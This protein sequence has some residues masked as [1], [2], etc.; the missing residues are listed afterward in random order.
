[1]KGF[2]ESLMIIFLCSRQQSSGS[3]Q[4]ETEKGKERGTKSIYI[5]YFIHFISN[6]PSTENI[7]NNH[8][9]NRD[10]EL[11][12]E[13]ICDEEYEIFEKNQNET[14]DSHWKISIEKIKSQSSEY[15]APQPNF[16]FSQERK[17]RK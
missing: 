6:F 16:S 7:E 1:M 14:E 4:C 12:R 10:I 3:E 2:Y 5:L 11:R 15:F 9:C 17:V 13:N 8:F